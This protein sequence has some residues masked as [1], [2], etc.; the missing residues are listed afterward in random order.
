M[1][2]TFSAG[3]AASVAS[4]GVE[5]VG[6]L[7]DIVTQLWDYINVAGST[8]TKQIVEPMFKE[9]LPG[10]LKTLHFTKIDLGKV[11]IHFDN[12][13]VHSRH[14]GVIKLVVDVAW[15]GQSDI[16]LKANLIGGLGVEHVKLNGRLSVLMCPLIERVPLVSAVQVA[17]V[18]PPQLELDFTGLAQVAD[19]SIID[20]TIRK[21]IQDILASMFVLP[22]RFLVKL[23]PANDYFK[24]YLQHLGFL[25]LTVVSGKGFVTPSGFFK[26]TPDIY[27]K[28]KLG[29]SKPW[30]T[31]T[32]KN[33]VLPQWHEMHDF[34]LSDHDQRIQ[35]EASDDDLAHDDDLGN[36][37]ITVGELLLAGSIADV[38]LRM[39]NRNT[40]A[41][42]SIK[43]DVYE[44]VSDLTSL[45]SLA[46]E[47]EGLYC[48][49][50]TILVAHATNV[51][52]ARD[53]IGPH[54]KVTFGD[55]KFD[56]PTVLDNPGTDPN[57]PAFDSA[58]RVL[59]DTKLA[60]QRLDV[61]LTLMDYR[62]TLGIIKIPWDS[63]MHAPQATLTDY[64]KLGN[65]AAIHA[66]LSICGTKLALS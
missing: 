57:N 36:G 40:G 66:R 15:D 2:D 11:P 32:K 39:K 43:C 64:F 38:P 45:E 26:D 21:I 22:N 65:G 55:S 24:T 48:G 14:K 18:N 10:P 44:F 41:S 12:I 42:I 37:S 61:S 4:G 63:I 23:D 19:L 58:F 56:T 9:M 29:A 53:K 13:D 6:F 35:I 62:N 59:L 34:L 27:C 46:N 54:C 60:A 52:G 31:S 33:S 20:D 7:N 1:T 28:V 51:P 25:R 49:I 8:M 3:I 47:K 17:F 16:E 30:R 50:L 5:S